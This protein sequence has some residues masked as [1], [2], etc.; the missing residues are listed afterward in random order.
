MYVRGVCPFQGKQQK[1]EDMIKKTRNMARLL[2]GALGKGM[3]WQ[4]GWPRPSRAERGAEDCHKPGIGL[5][6]SR[7]PLESLRECAHV[8]LHQISAYQ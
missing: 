7:M 4:E 2:G 1:Y 6:V 5:R 8:A 3:E